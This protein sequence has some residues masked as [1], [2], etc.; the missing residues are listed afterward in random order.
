MLIEI[1]CQFTRFLADFRML[2]M[3]IYLHVTL[4][5]HIYSLTCTCTVQCSTV[6]YVTSLIVNSVVNSPDTL[7]ENSDVTLLNSVFEVDFS[8]VSIQTYYNC[9]CLFSYNIS[10]GRVDT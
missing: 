8:N 5:I 3:Q 10:F 4:G 9:E 6:Q 1:S 7:G 2:I